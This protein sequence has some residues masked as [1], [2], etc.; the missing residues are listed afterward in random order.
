MKS[1]KRSND[2]KVTNRVSSTGR[3]SLLK[4]TFGLP[5]GRQYTCPGQTSICES[6]CYAGKL[7]TLYKGVKDA[8]LHNL[9]LLES[10]GLQG[11]IRLLDSMVTDF[12]S[13]CNKWNV[14]KYFRI[15]WD[16]D[17][18]SVEYVHAWARVIAMHPDVQFW[19]Y[20]RSWFAVPELIGLDNLSLYF[21]TDADN[22]ETAKMLK[23]QYGVKLAF[24]DE[25]FES[26]SAKMSLITERRPIRCPENNGRLPI[27][28]TAGSAC[29]ICGACV[30]NRADILFSAT[31]K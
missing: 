4:N 12:E 21:S 19:T 17:F 3:S 1:L 2:R 27:I 10:E 25:T 9:E 6:V 23:A 11:K 31:K 22:V 29:G 30:Y 7:E 5:S 20:T 18:Y 16:G 15:H 24:L 14:E 26:G 8:L 28:S 13:E